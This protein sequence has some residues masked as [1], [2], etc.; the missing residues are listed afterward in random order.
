[1]YACLYRMNTRIIVIVFVGVYI[2]V[3][4][5]THMYALKLYENIIEVII[6]VC[7]KYLC[8]NSVVLLAQS[9]VYTLYTHSHYPDSEFIH[10]F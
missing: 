6:T 9:Y 3:C 7:L 5:L 8:I 2:H 4:I 10:M 1:M